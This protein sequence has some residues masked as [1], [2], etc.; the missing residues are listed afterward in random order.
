M[1]SSRTRAGSWCSRTRRVSTR[2][3]P[4]RSRARKGWPPQAFPRQRGGRMRASPLAPSH[5]A[6]LLSRETLLA[7]RGA[8]ASALGF[9]GFLSDFFSDLGVGFFSAAALPFFGG[10]FG[11]S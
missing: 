10:P 3:L 9:F 8:Q 1:R 5:A 2:S 6:A 4:A 7:S 11:P